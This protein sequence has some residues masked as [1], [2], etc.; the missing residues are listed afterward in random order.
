MVRPLLTEST[1][2]RSGLRHRSTERE[3]V[4]GGANR[5]DHVSG[6]AQRR[7]AGQVRLSAPR[8]A[9]QPAS[10]PSGSAAHRRP[11]A[12]VPVI[13]KGLGLADQVSRTVGTTQDSRRRRL[14]RRSWSSFRAPQRGV[15]RRRP[16]QSP[17]RRRPSCAVRRRRSSNAVM[18]R[19]AGLCR[20]GGRVPLAV[21]LHNHAESLL[22][23][24]HRALQTLPAGLPRAEVAAHAT[25]CSHSM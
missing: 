15:A 3:T 8:S 5:Q 25:L 22:A 16:R 7:S 4:L 20:R 21:R 9:P 12:R 14:S 10:R 1:S 2:G 11:I 6:R 13:A 24:P 23:T 19:V 17:A 18:G